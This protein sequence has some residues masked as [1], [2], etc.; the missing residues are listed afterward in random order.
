[1]IDPLD[2]FLDDILVS[3]GLVFGVS[4]RSW[5]TDAERDALAGHRRSVVSNLRGQL[6]RSRDT[7]ERRT[8]AA[9]IEF[10]ERR[11]AAMWLP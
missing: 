9:K 1:M 7:Q 8:L 5:S 2:R 3:D 10:A 11:I 4:R 6:F